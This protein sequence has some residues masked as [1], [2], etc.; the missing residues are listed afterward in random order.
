MTF[1]GQLGILDVDRGDWDVPNFRSQLPKLATT[2]PKAFRRK[3]CKTTRI[4]LAWS[5]EITI[6]LLNSSG[7]MG[8]A[9]TNLDNINLTFLKAG[10][11][12]DSSKPG[13]ITFRSGATPYPVLLAVLA[14]VA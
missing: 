8:T 12:P 10:L 5:V 1:T 13:Q 4:L 3:V 9:S 14:Q 7:D 2:A 11:V 6:K